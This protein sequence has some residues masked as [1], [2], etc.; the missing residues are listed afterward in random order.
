VNPPFP[1]YTSGHS[2]YS[3]SSAEYLT[4]LTGSEYFPGGLMTYT[5]PAGWLK[6][7][8]GPDVDLVFNWVRYADLADQAGE[9]RIWGGIHPPIDDLPARVSG[10]SIGKR[11]FQ[12][13]Q[14]LFSGFAV[15]TDITGDGVVNVEDLLALVG[16]WGACGSPPC[17]GDFNGDGVTNVVDLLHLLS[18][19]G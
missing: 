13:A 4:G 3:R 6:F 2:T 15:T 18:E 19:W 14:A 9:S 1:G 12:R 8:Q 5:I 7:E 10:Y 11:A 16:T 17:V